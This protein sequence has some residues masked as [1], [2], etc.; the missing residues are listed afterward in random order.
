MMQSRTRAAV[1]W[2]AFAA[3]VLNVLLPVVIGLLQVEGDTVSA[4][5]C[6]ATPHGELPGKAP[7]G[8]L[9][10]HCALCTVPVGLP[11]Q[12]PPGIAHE[13]RMADA[14]YPH[15]R[16]VVPPIASRHGQIQARAPPITS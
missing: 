8:L 11:P 12:R 14:S 6:S 4:S 1:C 13:I 16:P 5:L 10:H 9:V 3:L 2:A 7:P 15:S